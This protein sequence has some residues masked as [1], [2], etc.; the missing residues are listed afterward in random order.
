[1]NIAYVWQYEPADFEKVA[2]SPLHIRAVVSAWQRRGHKV[3]LIT[4][5]DG[6][7]QF[8]DDLENWHQTI[9]SRADAPIFRAVERPV[10]RLQ[11][12][13]HLPYLRAFDSYRFADACAHVLDD[14]D[15]IYE[16]YWLHN[17]GGLL[18]ARRLNIPL[19]LEVNGDHS[20][21]DAQTLKDF[22]S[23]QRRVLKSIAGQIL[24]RADHLVA[25]SAPLRQRLIEYWGVKPAKVTVVANGANVDQFANVDR[26]RVTAF[27]ARYSLSQKP[28]IAFVGTFKPWH[29]ISA[30]LD[31]FGTIAGRHT[32]VC[33]VLAG[34]GPLRV[35]MEQQAEAMGIVDRVLFTGRLPQS[36]I[37]LLLN[38]ADIAV[39]SPLTTE[40][41]R[42]QS[43]LK[44]FEYMAAGTAIVAPDLPNIR[45]VVSDGQTACLTVP[46]D[47]HAF[48]QAILTLLEDTHLREQLGTN[49][50]LAAINQYSWDE[51]ARVLE[52]VLWQ[53]ISHYEAS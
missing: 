50:R 6:R 16:R 26:N 49:A 24:N 36:E 46:D 29:G 21:E 44:L 22:S 43:P 30:L 8:T 9:S 17:Y 33:F 37:A 35:E 39:L 19:V 13:L 3:R 23:N 10:R 40:A 38:A 2:A 31:A 4:F 42:A 5:K 12:A 14:Y 32:E 25:V 47:I 41:M 7:I 15:L 1:M 34:D 53:T 28:V 51:T 52:S 20:R 11:T 45:A 18:A 27:R 48:A